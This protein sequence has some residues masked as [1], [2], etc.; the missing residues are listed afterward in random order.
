MTNILR[1]RCPAC[2]RLVGVNSDGLYR[3]HRTSQGLR[4]TQSGQAAS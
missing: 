2:K 3:K 1:M 4:C